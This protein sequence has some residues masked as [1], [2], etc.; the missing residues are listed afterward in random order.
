MHRRQGPLGR[1]V[2]SYHRPY[3]ALKE[4]KKRLLSP[5]QMSFSDQIKVRSS[6]T[7]PRWPGKETT[8][9]GSL[10]PSLTKHKINSKGLLLTDLILSCKKR[11]RCVA[12]LLPDNRVV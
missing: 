1:Q 7:E 2:H 4:R 12:A 10:Q 6:F 11:C 3:T 5:Q 9:G 8:A